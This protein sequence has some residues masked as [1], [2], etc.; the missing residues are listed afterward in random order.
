MK[1][2]RFCLVTSAHITNNP[3]AVKEA[4]ALSA[5]GCDVRVVSLV[6]DPR[7]VATDRELVSTRPWRLALV[8]GARHGE[9]RAR[10]MVRTVAQRIATHAFARGFRARAVAETAISRM[11]HELAASA[12]AEPVDVVVGHNLAALPAAGRA[13]HRLGA[14]LGFDAEDL[15]AE[16]MSD[17][18]AS[19]ARRRL[20]TAAESYWLPRCHHLTAASSG[21]AD[22][23]A[24][25]YAVTRPLVVLNA[26]PRVMRL[27][28]VP[29]DRQDPTRPS[30]YWYSQ[31]IGHDRGLEDAI[32]AVAGLPRPV[33]LHLRGNVSRAYELELQRL[34]S[35]RGMSGRLVLH[36]PAPPENL[37]ALA[38]QHDVGLAAEQPVCLNRLLCATNK[39]FTYLLAGTAIAATDTPGQ[40]LILESAPGAGFLFRSGDVDGLRA[41]LWRLF[42]TPGGLARARQAALGAALAR[43]NWEQESPALVSYLVGEHTVAAAESVAG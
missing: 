16:E 7:L 34:A 43:Y 12:A 29:P 20:V 25:R 1:R 2:L 42:A 37:V 28:P 11:M 30:L 13:A 27:V 22:E 23:I 26:F 14:R 15:H 40:R 33:E 39:L 36:P 8:D 19:A 41:G 6:T 3:R 5:A 32:D 31:T 21:I 35:V 17:G 4:D 18:P 9:R 10:W 24:R 38:A